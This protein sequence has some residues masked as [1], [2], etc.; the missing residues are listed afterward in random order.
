[1]RAAGVLTILAFGLLAM[2]TSVAAAQSAVS[3]ADLARNA[4]RYLEQPIAFRGAYCYAAA[5]GYQCTTSEPRRLAL[6]SMP[7]GPATTAM[8]DGCGELDGIEQAPTCRFTL[9]IV[10]TEAKTESGSYV[11]NKKATQGKITV[12]TAT[13]VSAR[14]Q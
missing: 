14:K 13:V 4:R 12:V 8:D 2:L 1:M 3:A 11:R 10:P 5:R 6:E 7:A 9:Q